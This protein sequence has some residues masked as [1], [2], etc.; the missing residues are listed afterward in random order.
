MAGILLMDGET[1]VRVGRFTDPSREPFTLCYETNAGQLRTA[2][3]CLLRNAIEAAPA[4]G[5]AGVRLVPGPG[6][7]EVLVSVGDQVTVD[8]VLAR[9]IPGPKRPS[10]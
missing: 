9:L 3:S 1:A 5:W 6:Q 4:D 10:R 7:V 2:L 8:Q